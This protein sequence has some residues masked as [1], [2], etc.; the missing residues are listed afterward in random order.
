MIVNRQSSISNHF[1]YAILAQT[2]VVAK[3]IES[4]GV[5]LSLV[6]NLGFL[7]TPHLNNVVSDRVSYPIGWK[8]R[9]GELILQE[10]A[11]YYKGFKPFMIK[12]LECNDDEYEAITKQALVEYRETR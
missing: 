11:L 8:D 10:I 9:I 12:W 4:S 6:T 1:L 2:H 3:A 7:L 5:D